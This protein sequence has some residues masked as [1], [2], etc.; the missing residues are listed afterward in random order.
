MPMSV[1]AAASTGSFP[2]SVTVAGIPIRPVVDTTTGDTVVSIQVQING[3][4]VTVAS[5][6]NP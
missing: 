2:A 6:T 3:V 5:V 1:Y 4:W